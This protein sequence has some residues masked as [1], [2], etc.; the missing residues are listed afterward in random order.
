MNPIVAECL[1][2]LELGELRQFKRVGIIPL[3]SPENGGPQ[4]LALKEALDQDLLVVKEV[5]RGGSVPELKATNKSDQPI[6]LL[7]GEELAGAKQNRVLN[8][9]I[10]LKEQSETIIPV[11]CTEQ[12]RWS[13]VS[14]VFHDSDVVLTCGAR[15]L[16][17]A[18]VTGSLKRRRTFESDQ[19]GVWGNIRSVCYSLGATAPTGAMRDVFKSRWSELG[20]YANHFRC[21][22]GQKGLLVFINGE[23]AGFDLL[24]LA[25]AYSLVH[26]KLVKSYALDAIWRKDE[27]GPEPST[28]EA[29]DFIKKAET[30]KEAKYQSIGHGWDYRYEGE[31]IV[32]S[33][34]VHDRK[35]IH[36]AFFRLRSSMRAGRVASFRS[37]AGFRA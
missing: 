25:L 13:Y 9:S 14:D 31:Q 33:A 1:S 36:A 20:E 8:T 32:G 17:A 37:R 28:A 3:F 26:A 35:V 5:D 7:D 4:Y 30:C 34:L 29:G 22:P 19:T 23:V 6:L 11:S 24:S 2:K 12:G 18:S 21:T 16:K 10:L 15:T 27:T